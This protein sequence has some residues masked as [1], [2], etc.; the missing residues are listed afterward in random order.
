M[1]NSKTVIYN[2]FVDNNIINLSSTSPIING[3]SDNHAQILTIKNI[4]ATINKLPLKQRTRLIYNE[5]IV[6]FQTLIT[7]KTENLFIQKKI[8]ALRLP[9]FYALSSTFS[10]LVFQLDTKVRKTRMIGLHKE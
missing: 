5:I 10:K 3:L 1:I 7:K 6:N 2:I 9:H 4:H 8:P